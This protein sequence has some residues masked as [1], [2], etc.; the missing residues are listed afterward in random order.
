MKI[1][2]ICQYY[3]P[4][5]FVIYKLMEQ[6]VAFGHEVHVVTGLPNYGYNKI[7]D[8]YDKKGNYDE[9]ING[10]YVH[11]VKIIPRKNT[12][13]S[14]CRNYLS[15]WK[16][17][18][19]YVKTLD[20]SFDIVFSM[21]LSPVISASAGNKYQK[22]Y[23][24]PHIH[25]C[26]DL[27]PESLVMTGTI[28][29][30]GLFYNIFYK[31]SKS[32]YSKATRLLVSSPSFLDYFHNVLKLDLDYGILSQPCLEVKDNIEPII[33][34]ENTI[35]IVYCGNIG[36]VQGL[37]YVYEAME[38]YKG[39]NVY[40]HFIGMGSEK[41]NF[42]KCVKERGLE[43]HIIDHGPLPSNVAAAYFINAD[44]LYVSLKKDG[45]VGKTIPNKLIFYMSFGKPLIAM[46]DHDARDI[47]KES[48]GAIIVEES[49]TSLLQGL[50][51]FLSLSNEEKEKLGKNNQ[52]YYQE[53]FTL[54][55]LTKKLEGEMFSLK[56]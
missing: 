13:L 36:K 5:P 47:L 31:W 22:K 45:Y 7:M 44:A 48:K 15:F 38:K 23:K 17:S 11:R 41:E 25:Y 43:E 8:G 19:K 14:I 10:V 9:V 4:E 30:K 18:K 2:T 29:P 52:V 56:K 53:Y 33:Y 26:V 35:N 37:D 49:T 24:V 21:T 50:E 46:V 6:L 40:F 12:K 16:N 55:S 34:K 28:K 42:F 54:E 39:S 3:Y 20:D 32:V 51:K 1:L 27:W